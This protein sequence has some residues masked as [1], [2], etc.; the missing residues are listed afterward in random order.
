VRGPARGL[1]SAFVALFPVVGGAPYGLPFFYD[2]LVQDLGRTRQQVTL[3]SALRI[4]V[5]G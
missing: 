2:F 5:V 3:G 1:S 4:V